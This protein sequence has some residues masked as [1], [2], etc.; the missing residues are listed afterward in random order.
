M[1]CPKCGSYD[2]KVNNSRTDKTHSYVTEGSVRRRRE[3]L[4]CSF[5]FS[6]E[7]SVYMQNKDESG[8]SIV[9]SRDATILANGHTLTIK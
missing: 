9:L 7:E 3:C 8:G 5:K 6:T 2:T 1:E 4:D